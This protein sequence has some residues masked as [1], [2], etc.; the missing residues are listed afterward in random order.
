MMT[1]P[2]EHSVE[3]YILRPDAMAAGPR[4][5][6]QEHLSACAGCRAVEH[7]LREFHAEF[8]QAPQA[9]D[10]LVA[11]VTKRAFSSAGTIR[12]V[13]YH[14]R[15][16][17]TAGQSYIGVLAAMTGSAGARPGFE[18]V[19]SY[20]SEA[21]HILLRV[22][23]DAGNKRVK[24]YYHAD[25]P[26]K[27]DGA[28]VSIPALHADIVLDD[29]G[30]MEIGIPEAKTSHEWAALDAMVSLPVGAVEVPPPP[31]GE[32]VTTN[33]V[34]HSTAEY[35]VTLKN[36]NGV[37][38][39]LVQ[40]IGDAVSVRRVVAKSGAGNTLI[41]DVSND[42]G[43]FSAPPATDRLVLRFYL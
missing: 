39:V 2:D 22:R 28:I 33:V 7:S 31:P 23:Q 11:R 10:A 26:G 36:E 43:T 20:A 15:P 34:V 35:A 19:A 13:H 4:K 38:T 12:L 27:R 25:D 41:V 40:P 32:T 1:H 42:C 17:T 9:D 18:T 24:V 8:T 30:Q 3:L 16:H 29:H 21:D 5:E 6:L 37:C 14:P